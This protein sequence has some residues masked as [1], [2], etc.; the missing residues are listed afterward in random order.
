MNNIVVD[1]I[2][3]A[4]KE[5]FLTVEDVCQLEKIEVRY[6]TRLVKSMGGKLT[7]RN[8]DKQYKITIYTISIVRWFREG[9]LFNGIRPTDPDHAVQLVIEH[10]VGHII[11]LFKG[12]KGH[13]K[14]FMGI[15]RKCFG[16]TTR[17]IR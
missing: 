9:K 14:N 5:G 15:V 4:Y 13:D 16:H 3:K 10:E 7:Y 6:S 1:S 8:S 11:N 12:G 2:M 17:Y